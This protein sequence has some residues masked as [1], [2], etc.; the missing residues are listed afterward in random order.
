MVIDTLRLFTYPLYE[1]VLI[2]SSLLTFY[3]LLSIY[4]TKRF[5]LQNLDEA[6]YLGYANIPRRHHAG[7][8]YFALTNLC[9]QFALLLT[10]YSWLCE[11]KHLVIEID[12]KRS[13]RVFFTFKHVVT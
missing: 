13:L 7:R 2:I 5:P 9:L 1:D 8:N 3:Q 12:P 4:S 6:I 11:T 10:G